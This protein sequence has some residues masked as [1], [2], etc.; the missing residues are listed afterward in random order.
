LLG[1][2]LQVIG[3]N[4]S[5]TGLDLSQSKI[6][7]QKDFETLHTVV[8]VAEPKDDLPVLVVK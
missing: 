7:R 3:L 2:C 5:Q 1:V 8:G 6:F 4:Y